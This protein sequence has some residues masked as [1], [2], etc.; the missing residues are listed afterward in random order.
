M[1]N[2]RQNKNEIL[3]MSC[4]NRK[5]KTRLKK[6]AFKLRLFQITILTTLFIDMLSYYHVKKGLNTDV[7]IKFCFHLSLG[8]V[9][10]TF[11]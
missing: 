4:M 10:N 3:Y 11:L 8:T 6:Y 5:H 9:F 1:V 2:A 7:Q